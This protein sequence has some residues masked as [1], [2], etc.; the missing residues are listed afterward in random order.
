[1]LLP[2]PLPPSAPFPMRASAS[3]FTSLNAIYSS[4]QS[5]ILCPGDQHI[6]PNLEQ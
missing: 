1:M 4:I 3:H 2:L 6:F 5:L